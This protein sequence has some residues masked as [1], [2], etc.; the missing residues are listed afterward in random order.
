MK[1]WETLSER[2]LLAT[3]TG[4]RVSK[5]CVRLP[6]GKIVDDYY[7]VSIPDYVTIFATTS[8]GSAVCLRQY[9]HGMRRVALTLPGGVIDDGEEPLE[10]ARRELLEE[11]GYTCSNWVGMGKYIVNGN[12]RIANAWLFQ[13]SNA[14]KV[15]KGDGND[16]EDMEMHLI[17]T[18]ELEGR[19][20]KGEFPIV[21]HV[22]AILLARTI[23]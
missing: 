1:N 4:L 8:E 23:R 5:Q 13:A 14:Q 20:R 17:D 19:V 7:Q 11:T 2:N 21:S 18:S 12:Q 10:A 9:K 3:S 6:S 22:A 15:S 16:L